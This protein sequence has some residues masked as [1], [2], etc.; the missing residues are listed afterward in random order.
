MDDGTNAPARQPS[1]EDAYNTEKGNNGT[2]GGNPPVGAWAPIYFGFTTGPYTE[3]GHVAWAFNHGDWI[4]I[5]D[6]EV[7]SGARGIYR[8]IGEL[9]AW[10]S[11]YSPVY[12]GWSIWLDG[13]QIVEEYGETP[14]MTADSLV[15]AGLSPNQAL[16]SSNGK[17]TLVMQSDGNLVIY[18]QGTAIWA[19][20]TYRS[21]ANRAFMQDDG[22]F[23]VYEYSSPK[24]AS[25][26]PGSGGVKLVMQND[27]NLVI[28][29]SN[30]APVWASNTEGK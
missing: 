7:G 3:L 22:N 25:Q 2:R 8:S 24:W 13:V 14:A 19:S 5:R 20:D 6:S 27:G 28:Y 30:N 11:A 17:Y 1:A 26:T 18:R 12:R 23:V 15:N 4:E 21:G 16:I 29:K 10:F 9:L